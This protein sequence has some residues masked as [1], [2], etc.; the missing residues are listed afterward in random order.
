MV[1]CAELRDRLREQPA[2]HVVV[3]APWMPA[4]E[5]H[6]LVAAHTNTRFA[7]NCHSNVGFLQAD[8]NGVALVREAMEIEAATPNF[9]L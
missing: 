8:A 2:S 7:M 9:H 1:S 5:T 3:S 4:L 6:R